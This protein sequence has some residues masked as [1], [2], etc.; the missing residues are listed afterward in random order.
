[1]EIKNKCA[2]IGVGRICALFGKTRHAYYDKLWHKNQRSS[3]EEIIVELLLKLK[4]EIHSQHSMSILKMLKPTLEIHEIQL[5]WNRLHQIRTKHNLLH[6]RKRKYVRTT[7][8]YHKFY[9]YPNL[10]KEITTNEPNQVWVADITYIRI[11]NK[12]CFL[13]LLT[14]VYSRYIVGYCL[15]KTLATEGPILA[16]NNA[17]NN[18]KYKP[19]R[20]IHHSD[21][22]IQYCCD[23][24]TKILHNARI[25]ISMAEKGNPYENAIAERM[26]GILKENYN[27]KQVFRSWEEADNKVDQAIA[28]YNYRRPH[29]S[30]EG[31]TP[32]EA[33]QKKGILNKLWKT[34][35]GFLRNGL[36]Q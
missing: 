31:L 29:G 5:G 13:S 6:I 33:H 26:N 11:A 30:I 2:K 9:K 25:E 19:K 1:M 15:Y 23:E 35:K 7:D 10:I 16:L 36:N 28:S 17:I 34:K 20:L 14:D 18:L 12:F 8:S 27:L 24:Y 32:H 4:D 22:G 21:R 3:D